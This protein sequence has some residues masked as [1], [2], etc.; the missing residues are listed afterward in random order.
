MCVWIIAAIRRS[1]MAVQSDIE[2][3]LYNN[4]FFSMDFILIMHMHIGCPVKSRI[5]NC[6]IAKRSRI[7]T[8]LLQMVIKNSLKVAR[9]PRNL[10][11]FDNKRTIIL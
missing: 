8:N 7:A 10:L 5:L 2:S 11:F 4:N 9:G 3:R 6:D 1:E